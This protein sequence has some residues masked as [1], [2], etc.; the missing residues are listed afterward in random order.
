MVQKKSHEQFEAGRLEY[1][2]AR[3][4]VNDKEQDTKGYG[5]INKEQLHRIIVSNECNISSDGSNQ[6]RGGQPAC[7]HSNSSLPESGKPAPKLG[8]TWTFLCAINLAG[9]AL[10]TLLIG[11]SDAKAPKESGE[12]LA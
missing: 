1:G 12:F 9:K 8:K 2:F 11:T 3:E 6:G 4:P 5:V 10:G 7:S